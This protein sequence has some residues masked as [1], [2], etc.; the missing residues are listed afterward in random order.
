MLRTAEV[1]C[2]FGLG[3]AAFGKLRLIFR[4]KDVRMEGEKGGLY[5]AVNVNG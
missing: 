2:R 3:W 5:S 4:S 1:K